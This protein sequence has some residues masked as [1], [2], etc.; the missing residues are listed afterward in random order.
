M[1]TG[2][3]GDEAPPPNPTPSPAPTTPTDPGTPPPA[4]PGIGGVGVFE[5]PLPGTPLSQIQDIN[6]ALQNL[7]NSI[8]GQGTATVQAL[9]TI[10]YSVSG[11]YQSRQWQAI[12][13][14]VAQQIQV[15][16]LQL[17]SD[18]DSPWYGGGGN[19]T[20]ELYSPYRGSR[21][22]EFAF[23]TQVNGLYFESTDAVAVFV[24]LDT[25]SPE[26]LK[27]VYQGGN[28]TIYAYRIEQVWSGNHGG[29]GNPSQRFLVTETIITTTI[30]APQ[31]QVPVANNQ[32]YPNNFQNPYDY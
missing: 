24:S 6:L 22:Y 1:L 8:Q 27:V 16:N 26:I 17:Y 29:Y 20:M 2:C 25:F 10:D 3:G 30:Q 4:G 18:Y 15:T 21:Y 23:N 9:H 13:Q 31:Y 5:S 12:S 32:G 28:P 7:V 19:L 11:N 14:P